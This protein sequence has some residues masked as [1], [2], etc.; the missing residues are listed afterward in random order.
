MILKKVIKVKSLGH[1]HVF[2]FYFY[3]DLYA[4]DKSKDTAIENFKKQ[5]EFMHT[6]TAN[7]IAKTLKLEGN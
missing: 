1:L 6:T 7:K 3:R 2:L 4:W 5:R